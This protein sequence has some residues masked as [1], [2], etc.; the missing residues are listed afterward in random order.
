MLAFK[1]PKIL[2][3]YSKN[4]YIFVG[5]VV[6]RLFNLI[7]YRGSKRVFNIK[8]LY[9]IKNVEICFLIE[10]IISKKR[11]YYKEFKIN[12][13]QNTNKKIFYENFKKNL[14]ITYDYYS[15]RS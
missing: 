10:S 8:S 1:K 9:D 14:K 4:N 13:D 5:E 12:F 6:D 11:N 7:S 2:N 15:E 3:L